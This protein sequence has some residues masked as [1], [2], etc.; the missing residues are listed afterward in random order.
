MLNKVTVSLIATS[1]ILGGLLVALAFGVFQ[2]IADNLQTFWAW[3]SGV[4]VTL[5][6]SARAL[7]AAAPN[8]VKQTTARM[9]RLVPNVPNQLKRRAIKNELESTIN[10]AFEQF[11]REGFVKHEISISW[12]QPGEDIKELFF[13][14][15]KAY[16]KLDYSTSP[17][18]NLVE[19]ALLFCRRG[20]LL[21]ETRQYVPRPLIRAIDLQFVDEILQRQR[22][23]QSRGYFIHE[24]MHNETENP[25]T[26]RFVEKIQTIR[27]YG[28]FTRIL[29]PELR[30]YAL[31]AQ[32]AWTQRMHKQAIESFLDF[33]EAT[34]K[35]REEGTQT[36]LIH[37]GQAIRTAIVLVGIPSKLQ[38]EGSRPYVRRTA[39]HEQLGAQTVYL[40]GY[41]MGVQYIELIARETRVRGLTERYSMELYDAAVRDRIVRHKIARLIMRFGEGSRF[42]S[43]HPNTDE[44]PDIEDDVEWQG[45]LDE[46]TAGSGAPT[47]EERG[48]TQ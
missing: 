32:D 7:W 21:P 28:L 19:A 37:V 1:L 44:W 15:G 31:L 34:V 40:L 23:P 14:A 11:H 26:V 8:P 2:G 27:Q 4:G 9:I 48:D 46:I 17:E 30:D 43:E 47:T 39:I 33:I 38:D 36:A 45:I 35:S 16:L 18:I 42:I 20:G 24:I 10:R 12:L 6:I 22:A 41:N 5:A 3:L 13:Q 29:L 25:E